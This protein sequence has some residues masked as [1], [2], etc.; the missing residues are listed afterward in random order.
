MILRGY[1]SLSKRLTIFLPNQMNRRCTVMFLLKI[2]FANLGR[3]TLSKIAFDDS[4][5][6]TSAER[7]AAFAELSI[8]M[9]SL[10]LKF[11]RKFLLC[12]AKTRVSQ[13]SGHS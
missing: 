10:V 6:Y 4:G 12:L 5:A 7:F 9:E 2:H 11:R 3:K 1:N 8:V 13:H